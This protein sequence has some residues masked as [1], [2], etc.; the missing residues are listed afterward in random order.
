MLQNPARV[1]RAQL[2]VVQMPEGG[3]YTTVKELGIGGIIM[4]RNLKPGEEEEIIEQVITGAPKAD[5][6]EEP[7]PPEPFEY[8]ED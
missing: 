8:T 1:M 2:K 5:E 6:E 4:L 3:R 7:E